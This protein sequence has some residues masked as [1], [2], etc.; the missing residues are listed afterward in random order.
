MAEYGEWNRKGAVLSDVTAEKEYGITRDFIVEGIKAGKLEYREGA[1]WG[2]PF[3][4]ILRSQ[5]EPYIAE[6][7]GTEHLT[8]TKTRTEL[9]AINKEIAEIRKRLTALEARKAELD[10]AIKG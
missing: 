6:K 8:S 4:R 2:N 5:L 1:V 10:R 3:L 7:L 9:R